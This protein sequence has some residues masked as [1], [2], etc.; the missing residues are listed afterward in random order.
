MGGPRQAGDAGAGAGARRQTRGSAR[1][2]ASRREQQ[3]RHD[4]SSRV[5]HAT[6][7]VTA[8]CTTTAAHRW[9][10]AKRVWG[11]GMGGPR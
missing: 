11:K 7:A 9:A 8:A 3:L 4:R 1:G 6:A 5:G 10:A 2:E